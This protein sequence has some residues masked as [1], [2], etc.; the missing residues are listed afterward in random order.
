[1]PVALAVI[2]SSPNLPTGNVA[3]DMIL[4]D[5]GMILLMITRREQIKIGGFFNFVS[6]QQGVFYVF[7]LSLPALA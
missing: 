7:T 3:S 5:A 4:I 2:N 1:M 6:F